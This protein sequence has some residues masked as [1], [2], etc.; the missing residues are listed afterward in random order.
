MAW[1]KGV[2]RGLLVLLAIVVIVAVGGYIFVHTS[3]FRNLVVSKIVQKVRQSTDQQLSIGKLDI[4]WSTLT[5][6]LHDV[7]LRKPQSDMPTFFACPELKVSVKILSLW[8]GK[9]AIEQV[10][11]NQPA[12]SIFVGAHGEN[13]L[14]HS[15]AA[16]KRN[17]PPANPASAP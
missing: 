7:V 16:P 12:V 17:A 9:F 5:V 11:L 3:A 6:T 13:N 8:H 14:P 4:N 10:V 2:L 1:K 15:A